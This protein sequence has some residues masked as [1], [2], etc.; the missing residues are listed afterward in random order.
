D[1]LHQIIAVVNSL[2]EWDVKHWARRPVQAPACKLRIAYHPND[3]ECA[4][5]LRLIQTKVLIQRVFVALE[6]ALN[7][8]FVHDRHGCRSFG[9]RRRKAPPPQEGYAKIV[10]VVSAH[11]VP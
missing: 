10:K 11:T 8:R 3:A 7:E 5:I 6:K 1:F 9:V 2:S 4:G